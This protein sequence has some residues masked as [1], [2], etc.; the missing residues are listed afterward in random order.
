MSLFLGSSLIALSYFLDMNSFF[1]LSSRSISGMILLWQNHDMFFN[2]LPQRIINIV[3]DLL[4]VCKCILH[5][6]LPLKYILVWCSLNR[7]ILGRIDLNSCVLRLILASS[8]SVSG[9]IPY[10]RYC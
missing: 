2:K 5:S 4:K 3:G 8:N 10:I 6:I 7:L 1:W 9:S